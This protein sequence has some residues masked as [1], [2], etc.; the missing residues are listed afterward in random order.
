M[1]RHFDIFLP[2]LLFERV[3]NLSC[4]F[5]GKLDTSEVSRSGEKFGEFT[6][7]R[8]FNKENA[9]ALLFNQFSSTTNTV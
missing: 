2:T 1:S 6:A 7:K 5:G 4:G 9:L 8:E 3:G